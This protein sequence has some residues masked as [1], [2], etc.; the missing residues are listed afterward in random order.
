MFQSLSGFQVRCNALDRRG[1]G[2]AC[3][4]AFQSL[5]GFQVRCNLG[6]LLILL[7]AEDGF[8][9]LSGFQV[10][11]NL[12]VLRYEI[13]GHVRFNPYRVFKFAATKR[14]VPSVKYRMALFQSLSGFQVRCNNILASI[15]TLDIQV[16]IPI[17]FSSSLQPTSSS[18]EAG[19]A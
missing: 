1:D 18:D 4:Y 17:G 15:L 19:H 12:R 9:S 7:L 6:D 5:S 10:R 8:Q 2:R 13:C 14:I 11:C 16:S 3:L